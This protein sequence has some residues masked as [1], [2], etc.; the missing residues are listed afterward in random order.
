MPSTIAFPHANTSLPYESTIMGLEVAPPTAAQVQGEVYNLAQVPTKG[1]RDGR[2]RVLAPCGCLARTLP[3]EPPTSPPFPITEASTDKVQ[4][5]ILDHYATSAFIMCHHQP[6]L[7]MSGIPP[8]R[9]LLKE[10]AEPKAIRKPAT[11]PAHW[12]DQ[13]CLDLEQDIALGVLE[14]VPSKTPTAWCS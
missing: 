7:L 5:W 12:M 2:G 11:V 3:P 8:L 6:L 9:L 13:V 4:S 1:T 10:G 14:C